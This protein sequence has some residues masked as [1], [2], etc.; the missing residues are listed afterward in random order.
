MGG[1]LIVYKNWKECESF[2]NETLIF[3]KSRIEMNLYIINNEKISTFEKEKLL[4]ENIGI[5][6]AI[7][8]LERGKE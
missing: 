2:I 6:F 8:L 1:A 3:L 7:M 5:E 4:A